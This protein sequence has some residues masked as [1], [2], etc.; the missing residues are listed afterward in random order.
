MIQ[1]TNRNQDEQSYRQ[2]LLDSSSSLKDFSLDRKKYYKKYVLNE[3]V[4]EK[5]NQAINMGKLTECILWESNL[6]D[7]KFGMSSC[8]STPSG[9]MLS[10]IESLFKATMEATGEDGVLTKNFEELSLIAYTES[11]FKI[12]YE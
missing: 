2:I 10:F 6:F 5:E 12:K 1:G 8:I 3:P 9:L 11:G 7:K 4:A